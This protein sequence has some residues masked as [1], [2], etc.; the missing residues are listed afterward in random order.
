MTPDQFNALLTESQ[1]IQI[2]NGCGYMA[3]CM[4]LIALVVKK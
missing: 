4:F 2:L 3:I 1:N